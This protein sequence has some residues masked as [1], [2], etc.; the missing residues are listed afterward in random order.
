[1][2]DFEGFGVKGRVYLSKLWT[3]MKD[4]QVFQL[5]VH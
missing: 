2:D 5:G 3:K 4:C 1:M